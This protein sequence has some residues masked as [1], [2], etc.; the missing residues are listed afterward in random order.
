VVKEPEPFV[1]WLDHRLAFV[2]RYDAVVLLISGKPFAVF[3]RSGRTQARL[4]VA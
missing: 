4:A 2:P 1:I 3:S